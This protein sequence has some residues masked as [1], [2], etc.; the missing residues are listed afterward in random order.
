M[1]LQRIE[2]FSTKR[3]F[4]LFLLGSF[5]ILLYSLLILYNNYKHLTQ[6]D[7]AVTTATILKQYNKTKTTKSGKIK[8]YQVL[9]LKSDEG[10]TFYTTSK[11]FT[12]SLCKTIELTIYTKH[13]SFYEY[14]TTFYAYSNILQIYPSNSLKY[15]FNRLIEKQHSDVNA[16]NIYKA[17]FNATPLERNLQATFSSLGISHLVAISG[18]HL[19]VLSFFLFFLIKYPYKFLQN[20]YFPYR[21]YKLD[22]FV[23]VSAIL[24]GYLIFL[25]YP[26]SLLRSFVMLI[27]GFILYERNIKIITMQT[28][29]LTAI[30][31]L[32]F[33]PKLFFAVG[34]WLSIAG[35][36]YIFLFLI[37]SQNRSKLWQFSLLPFFVYLMMLPF[38]LSIFG[39]FSIYHPLSILWSILFTL[40]YPL[41]IFLHVIGKGDFFDTF[42]HALLHVKI[43]KTTVELSYMYLILHVM[44]SLLSIFKKQALFVLLFNSFLVLF[45]ALY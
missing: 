2:L 6:F 26:P 13:I 23:I 39:N 27:I 20:R 43:L 35:V 37:H 21:N 42:L 18:F 7:T 17:L 25:E 8:T 28:L 19:G 33:F 24:L 45:Y 31:L 11:P 22:S 40:F 38:S 4:S 1:K 41:S 15:K 36:F 16:S 5:F 29:L 12:S 3:E 32:A 14:L 30:V 44:I 34:F 9:K 10:F